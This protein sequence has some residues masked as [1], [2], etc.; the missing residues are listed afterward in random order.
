MIAK[1]STE[2]EMDE[3]IEEG[4]N[5]IEKNVKK[6]HL[7][8]LYEVLEDFEAGKD[9]K[10]E[11][12]VNGEYTAER[13]KVHKEIIDKILAEDISSKHPDIYIFGGV[14]GS[15]KSQLESYVGERA[16]TI[17]N[18]DIKEALAK[19]S[20][21]PVKKYLLLH[22]SLLHEESSDI[23]T[24]LVKKAL[25]EKKDI[26]LDRTLANF[27]KNLKLVKEFMDEGYEI[28]TF[29]TQL[30]PHVAITR[31]SRRFVS[32]GRYV[33]LGII[34]AKGNTIN[35]N[36]IKMANKDFNKRSVIIDTSVK[37][38]KVVLDTKS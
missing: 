37:P 23:E 31:A 29:G 19:H 1:L 26:I 27:D 8:E 32:Q 38:S 22:A 33:P 20:P 25:R 24:E 9:T 34:K 15:G 7:D 5:Y 36:V 14:A 35:R 18:D 21:S 2:K 17:N 13:K 12:S 6:E 16:I 28:S 11:F 4:K 3:S 10:A 30:H